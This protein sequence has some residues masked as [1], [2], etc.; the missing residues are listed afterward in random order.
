MPTTRFT[1][2][3]ILLMATAVVVVSTLPGKACAQED[4][5]AVAN[6]GGS[7]NT[8]Q[9]IHVPLIKNAPFSLTLATEWIRPMS[10]GG[11]FTAVNSRPIKRDRD[12][13]LYQERWLLT[14]KG[15]AYPSTMSYIQ[16]ADP[17]AHTL[18][19]C[20]VRQH[21][22][23]LLTLS[24]S[25]SRL[26]P[27]STFQSGPLPNGKGMRVHEDLGAQTFSGLPVHEYRDTT[28]LEP[29]VLGNDLAMS[30]V[31]QFRYSSE[32]GFNLTSSLD[33]PQS[34]HQNFTVTEINTSDPDPSFFQMPVGYKL[35]DH[36]KPA[37][38]PATP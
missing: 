21:L 29:G 7:Q 33:N 6:D 20:N 18:L 19:N 13:R 34:G 14:P 12:G 3:T 26:L 10:N 11:T 8:L 2:L 35:V 37:P 25:E 4:E 17:N 30:I 31:R 38:Q 23:E 24:A 22:C 32:L 28:T 36:R 27:P 1:L 16:I 15:S 9:S 5:Q